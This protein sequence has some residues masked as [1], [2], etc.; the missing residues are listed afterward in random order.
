MKLITPEDVSGE[1]EALLASVHRSVRDLR[2]EIED[3]KQRVR[4]G[5]ET[6]QKAAAQLAS[7]EKLIRT[8]QSVEKCLVEHRNRNAGV[9]R[10][11]Y[12]LDLDRAR[13]EIGCRL[14][15]LRSCCG[16]GEVSE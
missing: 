9:A 3:L 11:G 10:G 2:E 5:E 4:A 14:H 12:A 7:A 13:F 8:C 6:D 1:A 16:E 15:R